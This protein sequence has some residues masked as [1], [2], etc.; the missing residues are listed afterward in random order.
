MCITID[1]DIPADPDAEGVAW[2]VGRTSA[3]GLTPPI[4]DGPPYEKGVVC[5][6]RGRER[7]A[8]INVFRTRKAAFRYRIY[9]EVVRKVLWRGLRCVGSCMDKNDAMSVD[10]ILIPSWKVRQFPPRP[11]KRTVR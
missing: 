5:K 8:G 10:E 3:E 1:R 6:A 4:F 11:R 2:K 9:G 7:S